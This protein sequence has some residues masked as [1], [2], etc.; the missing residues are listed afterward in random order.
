MKPVEIEFLMKDNLTGGLDKAGLAVDILAEK[1]EKA[2][3]AINARILEQRKVIDRVNS[4]LHRMETQLQNMKP[5]PA[6]A[7][8]AADVAACRKVL[9]E[10]RAA[11]EGLEKEHRE[12]E[13]SV[14]NLRKEYER[15]SLEEER[16]VAGSK[17]L[18]DK[19][20][21]QKEVIGQIE[22]DIKSLEKAYQGAAPGKA[23]VAALDELNA[24]KKAL[25]EEKGA[26]AGLQAEQEKTR[27]SSKRLS[28][29]LRE[30]QDNMARMRLEGKQDTEEYRKM[31]AEAANLSDTLADL[32][33]Q[34]KILSHDDAN[35]QG[36]MS[37]VSGLAGLFTTATGALSL[38]ASENENLAKIQTRV[39]SVMAITMG[40]Q[41]VFNTLNKDSAFRLVTVVKMKNLL[42]AA[43]TR[44]AVALGISTGAAQALMATLTLGLSAVITGLVVAWDRYSTAQEKAAEK[45]REMVK[46]ESDGRAQMIKTRFEIESTLASL[47][48]FTGTKDEEKAKVEELNRKYGES[49]GYYDTIAQWYDIL[50]KKGE[51]YIRMLFLQ[52]KVQSLVNKATEADEKVNEIK[53]SKP[54]DV[55]G[56]MGWFARMGLYMAQSE[57]YGQVDAQ[58]M[59]SEY[60]EKAKEKAVRE[61]EEV[62]DGYL[63]EA[64]KLQEEYL[65]IGKEFDLGDHAKPDPNA[66]KKEKQSEEQRASELLKLQM[67]NR[68]S[69]ID[70]LKESGEK[71]R[72]QIRLNYD[73]E[74]AELAAQEKKWKDAQKGKLTGE[75]ES[76]LKEAREKAVAARDGDLAKVTREEN[77]A[78][79]QSMLD[80]LKEYGTYQQKKLAIAQE[81]AEKI[82]KAQE[83]GNLGEVLRLGRQQKEETAAAEIASLKADIDWDGLFG[84]FGGL[85]EEQLRPTLVKLRKYAASDEYRNAGA[86]DKQVIS[87]LIAKLEDR[88]AGGINRNMFKDVSRDLSAY[89]TTL[90]ELTEAKEREKAAADALVVAQ[91]K[92]KKAAESGDPSAM[93]EA[94]ELVATAQEAFDAAS[95]S[96]A[97]LTEANDKAAQ[98]LRTSSTNAVSSLTGLA[99]GLQSLKSGSL[100]GVAQGL[101]KLGEATKNMGGVMGTVG[102]TLAETFSNGG[103]I[104]QIIAAVL[105]ILDVLKEGIGTLVSGILDSVLGAVNGILENILSGELFTQIGSSLF[106]GVRDILDTVTFGLFSSHGNAR[107]VNALVD[108]LTESNK[109][110][111]TAIEK[112]T[113]EMA[114]SGGARSTEYYRS[115]YEKQQQKIENDRQMLAAKMG[116]HSS[117]HSNN[118]YIGKA[119]GSGDWDTVSA[120]L[121]K[122]V[123]DTDSLW[124]LSP[125]ELAR[126][127]ELPDIWEKLH[128]GKYDQSQWLDEYVS[129]ANTLLELQRQWQE[130]ITDT[131]FDGIRSGMKD[132]LK[133]FETDSKDVIASVDEFMENA[134]LKSIVNGTY[135]DE[136]KKWQETFAEFMSDGILSKE[137]AD[138]LRTRYSDIFERARAKKEEMFDTAGITE[139]GKSTTQT[140]RAGGF[141]A[142]SQDQGTKLE[143]MFTSGLNHWVSIDEKT[144]DVAGRMASAEGHLAKIAE[145]TGKSAGFLGEIKEDIKRII[146]D[147]LRMKSS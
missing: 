1:S 66:A 118:Y 4:D 76:T 124:S 65:D 20:R 117:H 146:R 30:L 131:S 106:Y 80:Y 24:A 45:A 127:Q 86:E 71:R 94:E 6:Q 59:I 114:S 46:I 95:A 40:L 62:R 26:L 57:S 119:M 91:E 11:L 3:A 49:F 142:M 132:L 15:I 83:A 5:G 23:K 100:A 93:K 133:D 140:G 102:S 48:K 99:E 33:T 64:R 70:L 39:Q 36:F 130:A 14:R 8:L 138:T 108:R 47:K 143:G 38:F 144:E 58:S 7:E 137:E 13:K 97:T 104:G 35:L 51:K 111:T 28:M 85:L 105:S 98:D 110:L 18:T 79:R 31:A 9:D 32:N 147:G 53:A 25:E 107:E 44:L 112:L 77:D 54:E 96:V 41:Q 115:A 42:T 17:S 61:A 78:A 75:Q 87:E 63:A 113:D 128:S 12:A 52:A 136:L 29:Q 81:Y 122:S 68:Q 19:I 121:G 90:R 84:N 34:T 123:R 109:Y 120:Y 74:I 103:I 56:S 43:N 50:Q 89:Q 16:A 82:R 134:I 139:E 69:E 22:S 116:Y 2:A 125:E 72:R 27:A 101:G 10:E 88:S 92:Q 135:S 141:S 129:D 126:L 73:K 67:K 60:N 21:E 37:G 145:N 55:D